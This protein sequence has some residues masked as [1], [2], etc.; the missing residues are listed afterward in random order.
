[1]ATIRKREHQDGNFSCQAVIRIKR[2]GWIVYRE[3]RMF[4]RYQAALRWARRRE[5]EL[6][7]PSQL[8]IALEK[9][10]RLADLIRWYIDQFHVIVQWQRSKQ[11]ALRFLERH[12]IGA[13]DVHQLSVSRLV[14]HVRSRR[15]QNAGPATA[16]SDLVYIGVVL[17]GAQAVGAYPVDPNVAVAARDTCRRLHLIGEPNRRGVRP[18]ESQLMALTDYF[19]DGRR[20]GPIPM[21][22]IMWFA[23]YSARR[24]SEI[25]RLRWSDNDSRNF[26]GI[27]RD[28]KH[29]KHKVG[30]HRRFRYTPEG[31]KIAMRQPRTGE[32]IF[33]FKPASIKDAFR[34]ACR[35]LGIENLRFHDLRH[36]ATS[37][38]FERGYE[39]H[40]VQ[41]FTLHSSWRELLRYT[42]LR[43]EQI[44]ELPYPSTPAT[45]NKPE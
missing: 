36:E 20:G 30:N 14:Q 5:V 11:N 17:A 1:M 7:D 4:W 18:S 3:S 29:P 33:P 2:N 43:L 12:E 39:I 28:L 44:P 34:A 45:D 15:A 13:E 23:I 8:G 9:R 10:R 35:K 26:T 6:E 16:Q 40:E 22:D 37:R 31:W 42:H 21:A 24:E 19:L 41:Q 32:F 38:L 27:V 25:C